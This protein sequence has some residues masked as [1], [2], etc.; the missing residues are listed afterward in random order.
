MLKDSAIEVTKLSK[1]FDGIEVLRDINLTVNKGEVV[2]I[3]GSS[4]S[5]KSTLL[6]CMN[7]LETPDKGKIFVGE[8]RIG[9]DDSTNQ[10]MSN[11]QLAK[12]RERVGMV[13]QN[14]NLW[15][16]LDILHNVMLPLIKVKHMKKHDAEKVALEQLEKVGMLDKKDVYPI[17][18]SGGQKQRVAI[19]R[20]LALSPDVLLFDEPTSA[21]D[22]ER[23]GEVLGVMKQLSQEGYTMVVV[24]HEM[25]FAR[26]VSDQVVFLEK[27]KLIEKAPPE[28]FFNNPKSERVSQFLTSFA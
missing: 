11:K 14:F 16:H 21:L 18:L 24:T 17:T 25:D 26:A 13:F 6:R 4:G 2:S 8:E 10:P 5:G 23:V 27:G 12:I 3:L 7:W 1:Q 20:S 28:E 9:V 22:P 19:A 15:P